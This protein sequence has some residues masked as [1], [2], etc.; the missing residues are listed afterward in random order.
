[1]QAIY[2]QE[3][4]ELPYTPTSADVEAGQVVVQQKLVG[5][6]KANIPQNTLGAISVSGV[7]D[8]V[9][10]AEV[11]TAGAAVYWKSD[12]DPVDGSAGTGALTATASGN[13]F[14]GFVLVTSEAT[15]ETVRIALRSAEAVAGVVSIGAST[16]AAGST[17]ADAA[18]LPAGTASVYP[19]TAANDTKGVIINAAD[20][21]TGRRI[22]IG[23][24]VH[25][26]I[27]KVYPAAGGTINGAS[28]DAAFSSASGKGVVA[29]CLSSGANTWLCF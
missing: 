3:G 19:T 18:A 6:A 16:A 8:V 25:D 7:F 24:G 23:N 5:I 21:V 11:L 14:A 17:D 1:M 15:D 2:I 10:E 12:G 4:R 9:Q 22:F 26:K 29:I 20:K 28:A 27:L 13:V